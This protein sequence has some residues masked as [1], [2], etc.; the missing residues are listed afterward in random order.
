MSE[1]DLSLDHYSSGS[2]LEARAFGGQTKAV[3]MTANLIRHKVQGTP[4][5]RKLVRL[6]VFS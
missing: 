5:P 4:E 6:I 3:I 1:C 2:W